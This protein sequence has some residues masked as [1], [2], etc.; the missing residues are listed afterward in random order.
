MEIYLILAQHV[1]GPMKT[2]P[3][4]NEDDDFLRRWGG[5]DA[6]RIAE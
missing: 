1:I 5:H 3:L 6:A 4:A 2:T